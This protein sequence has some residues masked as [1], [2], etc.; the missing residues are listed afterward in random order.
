MLFSGILAHRFAF[1]L[2]LVADRNFKADHAWQKSDGD[3]WLM[4]GS[5]MAPNHEEYFIFL[6]LAIEKFTVDIAAKF[7]YCG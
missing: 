5:E 7:Q 2:I 1:K 6:T 4:D 3:L